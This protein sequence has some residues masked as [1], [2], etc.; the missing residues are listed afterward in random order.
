MAGLLDGTAS[1]LGDMFGETVTHSPQSGDPVELTGIFRRKP[2]EIFEEDG[3][4]SLI[5]RPT[6]RV[7]E[8]IASSISNGDMVTPENGVT[9]RVK[10]RHPSGS[11]AADAFVIFELTEEV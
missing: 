7:N 5:V 10:N 9:Y 2:M 3:S 11:P 8:P 1:L 6:L 4:S